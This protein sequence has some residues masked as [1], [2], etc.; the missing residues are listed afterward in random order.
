MTQ[1]NQLPK[2]N[3][4]SHPNNR[5]TP[6]TPPPRTNN[7]NGNS[8]YTWN[9]NKP[10]NRPTQAPTVDK[11][12]NNPDNTSRPQTLQPWPQGHTQTKDDPH[13]KGRPCQPP[14]RILKGTTISR[15]PTLTPP[16]YPLT[17]KGPVCRSEPLKGIPYAYPVWTTYISKSSFLAQLLQAYS[18]VTTILQQ[19]SNPCHQH[20]AVT[21]VQ[22]HSWQCYSSTGTTG[23]II[24]R[25]YSPTSGTTHLTDLVNFLS[26]ILSYLIFQTSNHE[27]ILYENSLISHP[28][29]FH[30][31][32]F[33]S[34]Q[35]LFY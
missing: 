28:L 11:Q 18:M 6:P 30:E 27:E 26:F 16:F 34:W 5:R 17:R 12:T 4:N 32:V 8:N 35:T 1:T 15:S 9:D 25:C 23:D 21:E 20:L 31:H 14:E 3:L 24:T 33:A 29:S 7:T 19:H 2:T 10:P 22:Q 13:L